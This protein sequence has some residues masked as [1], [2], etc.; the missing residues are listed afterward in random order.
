MTARKRRSPGEGGCW[1]YQTNAGERFGAAGPVLM[2]DGATE[3]VYDRGFLARRTVR[4]G[5][6][7]SSRPGARASTSSRAKSGSDQGGAG[8]HDALR[9]QSDATD[10]C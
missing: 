8:K 9:C 3:M 6:L 4:P 7:T 10:P 1:P 2:P 5:W